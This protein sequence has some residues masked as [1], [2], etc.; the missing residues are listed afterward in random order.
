[1]NFHLALFLFPLFLAACGQLG[2]PLPSPQ[3]PTPTSTQRP[4]PTATSSP[5]VTPSPTPLPLAAQVNGTPILLAEWEAEVERLRQ[6]VSEVGVD[7]DET[8]IERK[9]LEALIVETLLA[10]GAEQEGY[11]PSIQEIES[12]Y[13]ALVQSVGGENALKAR[14]K[15]MGYPDVEAFR[16]ALARASAAAWM[17]DVI[18]Q[19]VPQEAEHVEARQI[20]LYTEEEAQAVYA[21][22]Q[23]GA[24]FVGLAR[25][26]DPDTWGYLGWMPRKVWPSQEM[27]E[28]VFSLE[29][30]SFS[31]VLPSPLGYHIVYVIARESRPLAP[32]ARRIWIQ[33]ALTDWVQQAWETSDVDIFLPV[34]LSA[35]GVTYGP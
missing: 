10:Q 20:L 34:E 27:E 11:R 32:W 21:R 30:G 9:A 3:Q 23:K 12:R 31:P 18:A 29:P 33:Q 13:Q 24:D 7:W 8:T 16:H 26:Y 17:R 25:I 35:Q 28:V 1:M 14:L 19:Q 22:L 5:T 15:A 4:T 6:A 2:G